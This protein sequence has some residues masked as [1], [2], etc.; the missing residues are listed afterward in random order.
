MLLLSIVEVGL[1]AE[2]A[3][4]II[5]FIEYFLGETLHINYGPDYMLSVNPRF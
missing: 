5:F 3:Y 1:E 4:Q 2:L